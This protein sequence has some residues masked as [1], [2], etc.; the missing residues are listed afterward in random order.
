M[1]KPVKLAVALKYEDDGNGTPVV[2][3]SGR[4]EIAEKI[5]QAAL[6]EQVPVHQDASLAQLLAQLEMGTEIPPE[7]YQAVAQVIAFV[8]RM[9]QK[10]A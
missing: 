8:W 9:D 10:Y 3:A 7:L 4:G 5:L 6:Q 1:D 2:I